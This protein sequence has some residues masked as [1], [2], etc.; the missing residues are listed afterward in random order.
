M[1]RQGSRAPEATGSIRVDA[2]A[3]APLRARRAVSSWAEDAGLDEALVGDLRL[4]VTELVTNAVRHA[5]LGPGDEIELAIEH[6]GERIRG[7][8]R[9]RGPG[10]DEYLPIPSG[11][12]LAG[13]GLYVVHQVA[14]AWGVEPGPPFGIWF[15]LELG[16]PTRE[17]R[18]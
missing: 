13:R 9:D 11:D 15:E 10:F 3:A 7:W 1:G 12:A 17:I 8:V 5:G 18:S 4:L 14:F 16:S 2:T 6:D